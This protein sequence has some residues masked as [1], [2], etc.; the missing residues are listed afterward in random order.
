[1]TETVNG[2]YSTGNNYDTQQVTSKFKYY[3]EMC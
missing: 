3:F 2:N 1:M